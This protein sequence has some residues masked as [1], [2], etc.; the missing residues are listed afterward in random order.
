MSTKKTPYDVGRQMVKDGLL[1]EESFRTGVQSGLIAGIREKESYRLKGVREKITVNFP[2]PSVTLP[3]K[4]TLKDLDSTDRTIVEEYKSALAD[5]IRDI[6]I[7]LRDR[8]AEKVTVQ[9]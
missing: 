6:Y 9:Y 4:M 3:K 2:T 5:A 7:A 1:T 8:Y